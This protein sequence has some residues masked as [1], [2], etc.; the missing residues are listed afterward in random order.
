[1][2]TCSGKYLRNVFHTSP[3]SNSIQGVTALPNKLQCPFTHSAFTFS[4]LVLIILPRLPERAAF[5]DTAKARHVM[6]TPIQ[7]LPQRRVL[8][9]SRRVALRAVEIP[10]RRFVVVLALGGGMRVLVPLAKIP[11]RLIGMNAFEGKDQRSV[12]LHLY[13]NVDVDGCSSTRR[14]CST[15][16][17]PVTPV[18]SIHCWPISIGT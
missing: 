6:F 18:P 14:L 11:R 15:A 13:G 4:F 8:L 2:W 16:L 1:M 7:Y 12:T 5:V 10:C 3:S 17:S 9:R